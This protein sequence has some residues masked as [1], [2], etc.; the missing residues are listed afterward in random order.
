MC[1]TVSPPILGDQKRRIDVSEGASSY[2]F[3][4][5]TE[6][7]AAKIRS[8][9]K[10]ASRPVFERHLCRPFLVQE[11]DPTPLSVSI[12]EGSPRRAAR[13]PLLVSTNA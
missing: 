4:M 8:S 11:E 10:P 3:V 7:S 5:P 1:R 13:P 2:S 9:A 12:D 6:D